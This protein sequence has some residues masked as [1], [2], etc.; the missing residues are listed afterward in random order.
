MRLSRLVPASVVAALL[1]IAPVLGR[2]PGFASQSQGSAAGRGSTQTPPATQGK[3]QTPT[4]TATP[5]QSGQPGQKPQFTAEQ[6]FGGDW[7]KDEAIRKEMKLSDTQVRSF[8]PDLQQKR[9]ELEAGLRGI[10]QAVGRNR[11]D[12]AGTH[13]GRVGV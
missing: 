12:V 11:S 8:N 6:Y 10:P 2:E 3:V 7:W 13:R 4:P 9:P 1:L 5:G